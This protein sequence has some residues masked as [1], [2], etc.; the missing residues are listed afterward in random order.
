MSSGK[1]ALLL[2]LDVS[3]KN[4]YSSIVQALK[5]SGYD[6]K[7]GILAQDVNVN[8]DYD[9]VVEHKDL[10]VNSIV[11]AVDVVSIVGGYRMYYIV[12]GKRCPIKRL[13]PEIQ[14]LRLDVLDGAIRMCFEKNKIIVAPI[15]VPAY[16]AKLG[17][18]KGRRCTVFPTTDLI[19]I[20]E[21]I[22]ATF[23][24]DDVV[25]DG[26]VITMKRPSHQLLAKMLKG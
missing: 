16:I 7:T 14:Q 26:N 19:A 24:N 23:V 9:F 2:V 22:G 11:D 6:I 20:L 3:W 1:E 17:Y 21:E 25:R 13:R 12:T 4:E 10:D 8:Y 18:L 15:A 5:E